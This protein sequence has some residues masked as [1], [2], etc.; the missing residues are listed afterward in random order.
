MSLH[1]T[2]G[3]WMVA[4]DSADP[5]RFRAAVVNSLDRKVC[6]TLNVCAIPAHRDDLVAAFLA[7]L[8]E[9]GERSGAEPVLHVEERAAA[10][11]PDDR[12]AVPIEPHGARHGV[13][14]G[15][16]ARG[17]PRRRGRRGR[18]RR[19]V[20]RPQPALRGVADQRRRRRAATVL[21][22]RRCPVRRRRVHDGGSTASTRWARPSSVCPTGSSGRLLARGAVLSGDSVHT[23]RYRATIRDE[24]LAR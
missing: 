12:V 2:G 18:G 16:R 3:A 13:G 4:G 8:D 9:A 1:G 22:H 10:L 14:V 17:E 21:R 19:A 6:N 7:A 23:V 24:H 5:D 11:L 15:R 20:Q